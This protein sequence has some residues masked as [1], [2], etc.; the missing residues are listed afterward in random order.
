[1]T[2]KRQSR[3]WRGHALMSLTV[4]FQ[5]P[6]LLLITADEASTVTCPL[7]SLEPGQ[8]PRH[9]EKL[10]LEGGKQQRG[11]KG[12]RYEKINHIQK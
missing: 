8:E 6:L 7:H 3:Y 9:Q 1:M 5:S 10:D 11:Q 12:G 2:F 4:L